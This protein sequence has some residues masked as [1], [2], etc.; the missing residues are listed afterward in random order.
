M[1]AFAKPLRAARA[2]PVQFLRMLFIRKN[3]TGFLR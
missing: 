2:N 3:W 1:Q